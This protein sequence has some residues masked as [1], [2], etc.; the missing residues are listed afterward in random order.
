MIRQC[1]SYGLIDAIIGDDV[2]FLRT[3]SE[4]AA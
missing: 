4:S 1:L 3:L 2:D